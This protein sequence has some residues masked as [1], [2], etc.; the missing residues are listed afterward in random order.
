MD[1]T[2]R[3]NGEEVPI[4]KVRAVATWEAE[5]DIYYWEGAYGE[6]FGVLAKFSILTSK[7]GC[8]KING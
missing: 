1:D 3:E 5:K 2:I 7:G 6:V 8:F 4:L